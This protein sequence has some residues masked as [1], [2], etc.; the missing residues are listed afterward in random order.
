MAILDKPALQEPG[1]KRPG[2]GKRIKN[3]HV[4]DGPDH[5]IDQFNWGVHDTKLLG[6]PGERRLEEGIVEFQHDCLPLRPHYPA[7][8]RLLH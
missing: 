4:I 2:A 1:D 8:C 5:E 6:H 3:V 7:P